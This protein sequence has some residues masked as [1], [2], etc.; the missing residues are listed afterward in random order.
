MKIKIYKRNFLG[1]SHTIYMNDEKHPHLIVDADKQCDYNLS[2]FK[3]MVLD[4]VDVWPK[5]MKDEN[6][7]DGLEYEIIIEKN[8]QKT[9][10]KFTN[11]FPEDIWRIGSLIDE[12]VE[13]A[14]GKSVR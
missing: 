10:Y 6:I 9:I 14:N 5:E 12:I 4:A 7:T 13:V 3:L 11:K 2:L 1:E 8:L